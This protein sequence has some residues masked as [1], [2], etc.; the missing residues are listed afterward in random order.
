MYSCP[1]TKRYRKTRLTCLSLSLSLSNRLLRLCMCVSYVVSVRYPV[2]PHDCEQTN[3]VH[4]IIVV[5]TPQ[6]IQETRS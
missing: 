5:R 2:R 6:S 3:V 1:S 4:I